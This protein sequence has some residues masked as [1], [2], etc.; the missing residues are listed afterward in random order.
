MSRKRK[1]AVAVAVASIPVASSQ[2]SPSTTAT[3]VAAAAAAAAAAGAPA[4]A[5]S[6][7]DEMKSEEEAT[8]LLFGMA[9]LKGHRDY[10]EDRILVPTELFGAHFFGIYDG[11]G[12]AEASQFCVDNMINAVRAETDAFSQSVAVALHQ[13]YAKVRAL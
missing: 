6:D 8:R 2:T 4:V 13:A 10:M 1:P 9:E 7:R 3:S 5:G 12:G 11:H